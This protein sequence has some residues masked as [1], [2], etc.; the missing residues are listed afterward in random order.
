MGYDY[1]E[2]D[3][4]GVAKHCPQKVSLRDKGRSLNRAVLKYHV[5]LATHILETT[6]T[7]EDL[8][9]TGLTCDSGVDFRNRSDC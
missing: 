2:V 4:C 1:G 6:T 9:V 8:H 7:G 5:Q 3:V